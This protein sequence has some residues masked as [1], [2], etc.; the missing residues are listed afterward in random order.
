MLI[1]SSIKQMVALELTDFQTYLA[2]LH[3]FMVDAAVFVSL[4]CEQR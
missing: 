4:Y 3:R 1:T 2:V